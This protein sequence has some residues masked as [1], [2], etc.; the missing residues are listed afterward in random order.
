MARDADA[1]KLAVFVGGTQGDT[2]SNTLQNLSRRL[3]SADPTQT[4]VVFTG[5]YTAVGEFPEKNSDQRAQAER[6]VQVHIDAVEGFLARGG[7]VFF[8]PGHRDYRNGRGAV[9][10]LR[11][12]INQRVRLA[13]SQDQAEEDDFDAM[14]NADCGDPYAIE[15]NNTIAVVLLNSAWWMQDWAAHPKTNQ[16]CDIKSRSEFAEAFNS[17]T[18]GYRTRRMLVAVHHPIDSLGPYGG[19]FDGIDHLIPPIF[20][21]IAI[22]AKQTGLIPEYRNHAMFDSF[23][24]TLKNSADTFGSFVFV[25]GHDRSLQHLKVDEQ[26][27]IISGHSGGDPTRVDSADE[28]DFTAEASGWAEVHLEDSGEGFAS[29]IAGDTGNEVFRK[30]LPKIPKLAKEGLPPPPPIPE[31]PV[32]STYTKREVSK[33][34]TLRGWVVG[35]FYR[36]SYTLKLDFD[37]MNVD[38]IEGGLTP[39]SIGGGSQTNSIRF[40]GPNGTQWAARAATKDSTRY[41]PYPFN[42][43]RPIRYFLEEGFTGIHPSAATTV[44]ALAEAL[45]ILHTRPRLMYLPDQTGI[46]E[47]RGFIGDEVVL[48]ERRPKEPKEGE[49][50]AHLGGGLSPVGRVE[51]KST[52]D[53]LEKVRNE[54]WEHEIDQ[55]G[56][57][58]ARLLDILIGDWDR[59]QDQ[60]RFAKLTLE[61]DHKY[62]IPIPRDRDQ[63]CAHYDGAFLFLARMAIPEI[64][65]LRPFDEEIGDVT[66]VTFNARPVDAI[67]LSRIGKERWM[68]IAREFQSKVTDE[69][70]AEGMSSWPK[71]AYDL[72]G[73]DMEAKLRSRRDEIVEAAE[74]Y[75][76]QVNEAIEILG[77]ETSDRIELSYPDDERLTVRLKRREEGEAGAPFFERTFLADETEEIRIFALDG[78]DELLVSGT[79]HS[80]IQIRFVGGT[81]NDRVAAL[82]GEKLSARGIAV[83]DREKGVDIDS[84][85]SIDDERSGD[86]YRNQ[87]DFNDPHHQPTKAAAFPSALANADDGLLLR[88]SGSVVLGGFKRTPFASS[89]TFSAAVATTTAGVRGSYVGAFPNSLGSLD[90]EVSLSGTTPLYTRNFFGFTSEFVNPNDFAGGRDFFRLR[91]SQVELRYGGSGTLLSDTLRLGVRGLGE[92][93]DIEA[94]DGRFVV[95]SED[96]TDIDLSSRVYAGGQAYAELTTLDNSAYP[97]RGFFTQLLGS[98]RSDVTTGT[99]ERIGTSGFFSVAAGTYIPF[100]RSQRFVLGTRAKFQHIVGD[101]PFYHAPTLGDQDLRA[102]NDEQ[103]SGNGVFAQ[104][105]DLRIELFRFREGLPG[106]VGIAASLDHGFAFGSLVANEEYNVIAGG[107]VFWSILDFVG[108]QVGYYQ[109]LDEG[110]RLTFSLGPLFANNGYVQ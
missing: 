36:D 46:G 63:A 5:N 80:D 50:P 92:F 56:W 16:G 8:M 26:V 99:E 44:P 6:E 85:I 101:F 105:L 57:L 35:D 17:L 97:K 62:Y 90:Q 65:R 109:G 64:R 67:F 47:F 27:Q 15:L 69:V 72:H 24:S 61:N 71:A 39:I 18:K 3:E 87:Y 98:V 73:R 95:E 78:D 23:A 51:Y 29:I 106:T 25:S 7:P 58:R 28:G 12:F 68:Q 30:A 83:Y 77:S 49:L 48:L 32:S 70:I 100:D 93:V 94:T 14:P 31:G 91:Q 79:P 75:Y 60:W 74:K 11:D 89:H 34:G 53:T 96:V 59:H 37:V 110:N 42:R 88:G 104:S 66:W 45:G 102:Y 82:G 55:E 107:S 38:E 9:R 76:Y 19:S 52:T 22:W 41:L 54:P 10:R 103:L 108:V 33:T 81:D 84:S 21:T 86:P 1:A 13:R 40:V 43:V 20:G 2:A 4:T